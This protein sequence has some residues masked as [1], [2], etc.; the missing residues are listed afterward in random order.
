M[1][2]SGCNSITI[3]PDVSAIPN[4]TKLL[5]NDCPNLA[6]I[7]E[8][9]GNLH[10]LVIMSTQNCPKL[11]NIPHVMRSKSLKSLNLAK[12]SSI[13]SFP[14]MLTKMGKMSRIDIKGTAIKSFPSSIAK[15]ID[16]LEELVLTSSMEDLPI[17]TDMFQNTEE[18][19][20]EGCPKLPKLLRK[21][22]LLMVDHQTNWAPKL[23]RL[24]LKN[25]DLLD[26]DL[27]LILS[28]FMELKWLVLSNNNFVSIP[29]CIEDLEN[30]LFLHVDDCKQL[31]HVSVLPQ[32]LQYIDA[33]N[34]I[35]LTPDSS[36]VILSQV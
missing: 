1:N 10:K 24:V 14:D 35:S 17:D 30:L 16:G 18:I 34:C 21:A 5:T 36:D 25:C 19:N 7:H 26:E 8:S 28:S 11:K 13:Q 20:V 31:A 3:V 4:L 33:R 9:A 6:E 22:I 27:G 12:C 2:F 29:D 32:Y 23:N 15:N